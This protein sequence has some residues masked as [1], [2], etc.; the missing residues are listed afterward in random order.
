MFT[1]GYAAAARCG[2]TSWARSEWLAPSVLRL[3]GRQ[4]VAGR[5]SSANRKA[6]PRVVSRREAFRNEFP[7]YALRNVGEL[8]AI[9]ANLMGGLVVSRISLAPLYIINLCVMT[10]K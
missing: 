7:L 3:P 5:T 10:H 4:L 2:C 6:R 1:S 9:H 8:R